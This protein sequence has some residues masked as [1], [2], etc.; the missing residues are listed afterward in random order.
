MF[1]FL[2]KLGIFFLLIYYL[3]Y[4][5]VLISIVLPYIYF[6]ALKIFFSLE[7]M[8]GMD[9]FFTVIEGRHNPNIVGCVLFD[10]F[11]PEKLKERIFSKLVEDKRLRST[12]KEVFG[13]FFWKVHKKESEDFKKL[14]ERTVEIME[15][16]EN[17]EKL[18]L[19]L[20]DLNRKNF[21]FAELQYK[22]VL[23]KSFVEKGEEKSL[24]ICKVN[25]SISDGLGLIHLIIKL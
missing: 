19:Y 10:K 20:C 5:G 8:R 17:E 21:E 1:F 15:S 18:N 12:V 23:V 14:Q 22:F 3:T 9:S 7:V 24:L 25:H 4:I 11:D 6:F 16:I 2:V 13:S